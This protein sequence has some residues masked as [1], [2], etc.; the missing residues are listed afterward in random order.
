MLPCSTSYDTGERAIVIIVESYIQVLSRT[1]QKVDKCNRPKIA[2]Y[3]ITALTWNYEVCLQCTT[4]ILQAVCACAVS[5]FYARL[6]R[7]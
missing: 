1:F 3:S 2:K 4:L 5:T 6:Y 7:M